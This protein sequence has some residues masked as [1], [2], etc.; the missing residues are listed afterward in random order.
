MN[1]VVWQMSGR[2]IGLVNSTDSALSKNSVRAK[3][4]SQL[5]GKVADYDGEASIFRYSNTP[6]VARDMLSIV[7]A[8]DEWRGSGRQDGKSAQEDAQTLD[9]T[10]SLSTKGKLVYWGFSYGTLLGATFASMF[11]D[12]VGRVML[13]GVVD[14]DHYVEPAWMHSL[15]DTDEIY[16]SFFTYCLRAGV[17]CAVFRRGDTDASDIKRRVENLLAEL[18]EEPYI[19]LPYGDDGGVPLLLNSGDVKGGIF[20][21]LYKPNEMFPVIA[22]FINTL[23]ERREEFLGGDVLGL[24]SLCGKWELPYVLDD[25]QNT[26]MCSDKR[27]KVSCGLAL[28]TMCGCHLLSK[29]LTIIVMR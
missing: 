23:L 16:D 18:T 13:D 10:D 22:E 17:S 3:A 2:E 1:R 11:P 25:S 6:N 9:E 15:R 19:I 29:L 26:V 7:H 21:A 28:E 5:C 12:K 8:W 24:P 14:A 4:L 20:A 27:Y